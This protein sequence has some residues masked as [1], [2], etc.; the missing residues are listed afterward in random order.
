MA[1]ITPTGTDPAL[2][3]GNRKNAAQQ[4]ES[5][6][7][8]KATTTDES[9]GETSNQDSI[10]ISTRAE[11]IQKLNEEFFTGN[12]LDFR[13]TQDF[14]LRLEEFKLITPDN[15]ASLVA[16]LAARSA[17]DDTTNG[18]AVREVSNFIDSYSASVHEIDPNHTLVG[19]LQ[20][21]K[22]VLDNFNNP[23]KNSL[24][25]NIPQVTEQLQNY[26]DASRE[27]LSKP[28]QE[29]FDQLILVL[30]IAHLLTPGKNTTS[31]IDS[32][33]KINQLN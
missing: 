11:N 5:A 32:Y 19:I 13:I 1:T 31:Q 25:I 28:D 6:S 21:A 27:Y 26:V 10:N 33:L 22:T 12:P 15:A 16:N 7:Y 3:A 2:I 8:S 18:S 29:D 23:T 30:D 17:P 20:E 9:T 24:K 4:A 14:I